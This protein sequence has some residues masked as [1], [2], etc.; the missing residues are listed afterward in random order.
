[1]QTLA[2]SD[3]GVEDID[4]EVQSVMILTGYFMWPV[5]VR[6]H[7]RSKKARKEM[8]RRYALEVLR[9]AMYGVLPADTHS[10]VKA[11]LKSNI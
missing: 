7:A 4:V 11:Y 5:W 9:N 1:V 10:V 3:A 6:A 2:E 8:A